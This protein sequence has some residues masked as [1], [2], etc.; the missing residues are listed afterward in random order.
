MSKAI[1]LTGRRFGRLVA[2]K[3]EGQPSHGLLWLCRCDCGNTKI[4]NGSALRGGYTISCGCWQREIRRINGR[5]RYH[6]LAGK[7]FWRLLVL[8]KVENYKANGVYWSCLCDCG[9]SRIVSAHHLVSGMTKSCGCIQVLPGGQARKNKFYSMYV[10]NAKIRKIPFTLTK[11]QL[12]TIAEGDCFYCGMPPKEKKGLN[13]KSGGYVCNGIDR[14][15]NKQGY[16]QSNCVP[17]CFT[18]NNAKGTQSGPEFL[19][20][21]K[22]VYLYNVARLERLR[23]FAPEAEP[24]VVQGSTVA[25]EFHTQDL[26]LWQPRMQP[27]YFPEPE[28]NSPAVGPSVV[29][30]RGQASAAIADAATWGQPGREEP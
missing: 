18:C 19:E 24:P 26:P 21:V 13:A 15:D 4:I 3:T 28:P 2:V 8:E 20:W 29:T 25:L 30:P 16:S 14:V 11:E 17:C 6:P 7:K 23:V 27:E 12:Y 10:K 22:R 9:V 5:N 1:D